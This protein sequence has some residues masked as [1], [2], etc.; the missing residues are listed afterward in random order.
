MKALLLEEVGK[1]MQVKE[2]ADPTL[3][4]DGV[5][6][7]VEA[8]GICR[9]DWHLWIG[10]SQAVKQFPYVLGHEFTGVI[11]E[12]GERVKQF[13]KGDRV[14]APVFQGDNTCPYCMSG[15]HNL[16]DNRITPGVAYWGGYG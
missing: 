4:P 5:I 16:C 8:N 7:K 15:H 9:S 6:I 12:V 2:V 14:I 13:K 3:E 1:P 10:D 11:E